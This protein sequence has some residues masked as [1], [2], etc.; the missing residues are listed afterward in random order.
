MFCPGPFADEGCQVPAAPAAELSMMPGWIFSGEKQLSHSSLR[1]VPTSL[2][3]RDAQEL[4]EDRHFHGELVA[5]DL[6]LCKLPRADAKYLPGSGA[7]GT[8]PVGRGWRDCGRS[9]S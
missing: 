5:L 4:R 9:G 1:S 7:V 3:A 2:T 6:L 8:A